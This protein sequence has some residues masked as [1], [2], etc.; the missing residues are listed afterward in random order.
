MSTATAPLPGRT[1]P[2]RRPSGFGLSLVGLAGLLVLNSVLGPLVT[3]VVDYPISDSLTNQLLGLEVVTLTLVVPWL[4]VVA[5]LTA[6]EHPRAGLLSL[7]PTTYTAYM[8]VQYVLGPEYAAYS[9]TVLFQVAMVALSGGLAVRGWSTARDETVPAG[10]DRGRRRRAVALS[11]LAGF[12]LLRYAPAFTGAATGASLTEELLQERPFFWS[13][14]LL[15]L[16]VVV[17]VTVAAAVGLLQ[18]TDAG[19]RLSYAVV[20]W[21]A[22]VPPS[23]AAMAAVMLV[24]DDPHGS[25]PTLALLVVATLVFWW[26]AHRI[27]RPLLTAGSPRAS[28]AVH[29]TP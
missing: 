16:G 6:R 1:T 5:V 20:G 22:L 25:V 13:I 8:F 26:L 28:T 17:P 14:V 4:L 21:F 19:E 10:T 2:R 7:G 23:V 11:G 9:W 29:F 3:G 12:V 27:L 15:D 24:R 18:R